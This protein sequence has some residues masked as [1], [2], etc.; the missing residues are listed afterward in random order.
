MSELKLVTYCGLYCELCAQRGRMPR[1]AATLR[2]TMAKEGYEHWGPELPG[3]EDFWGF[4]STLCD[5]E[6]ACP[7]CRQGGGP[8]WCGIRKCARERGVESCPFCE[9]RPC[10]RIHELARGYPTLIPD[11]VRLREIGL[12][13]WLR[14]HRE[15]AATG[16][17]YADI[18]CHPHNV[19]QD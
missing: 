13:A 15:R 10:E 17:A 1:Q 16:F 5:P 2:A 4:L 9:E 11:G 12:E 6:K 7:G 18:R 3:F 14:E 8:P 19:P